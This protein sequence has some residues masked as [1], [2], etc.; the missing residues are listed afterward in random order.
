MS[1]HR[2]ELKEKRLDMPKLRSRVRNE[3]SGRDQQFQ[4]EVKKTSTWDHGATV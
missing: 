2:A 1:D 4:G 3:R